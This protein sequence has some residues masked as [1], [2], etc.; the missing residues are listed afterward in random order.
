M[1]GIVSRLNPNPTAITSEDK[2]T[3]REQRIRA[4]QW[5]K[6]LNIYPEKNLVQLVNDMGDGYSSRLSILNESILNF[7]NLSQ[8][9]NDF[10]YYNI[11]I[12]KLLFK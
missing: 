5:E 12:H 3:R 4:K 6:F 10:E 8:V 11:P 9:A 1:K 7:A 2:K